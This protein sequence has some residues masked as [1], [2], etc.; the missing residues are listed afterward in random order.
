MNIVTLRPE[1]TPCENW[2]PKSIQHCIHV[3]N[4]KNVRKLNF[5]IKEERDDYFFGNLVWEVYDK[6]T[7][8]VRQSNI[9]D[10]LR[11]MREAVNVNFIEGMK[12]THF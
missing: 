11:N 12:L 9:C 3:L 10:L 6:K 1:L 4:H 7:K 8:Q 2:S 5:E